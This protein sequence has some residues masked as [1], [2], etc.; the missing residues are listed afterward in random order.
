[1]ALPVLSASRGAVVGLLPISLF[2]AFRTSVNLCALVISSKILHDM[3][4]VGDGIFPRVFS[5]VIQWSKI[6]GDN[7]VTSQRRPLWTAFEGRG[8]TLGRREPTV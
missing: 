7:V 2:M 8:I 5:C 1:M 3:G 4:E 6:V